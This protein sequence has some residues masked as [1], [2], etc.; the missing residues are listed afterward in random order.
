MAE[1]VWVVSTIRH[2]PVC[3][4][5][6]IHSRFIDQGNVMFAGP[7]AIRGTIFGGPKDKMEA[8]SRW[9]LCHFYEMIDQW[10]VDHDQA[11]LI[12]YLLR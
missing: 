3:P 5:H 12:G 2:G 1:N 6:P 11:T 10:M 8:L 7:H 4:D 9:A